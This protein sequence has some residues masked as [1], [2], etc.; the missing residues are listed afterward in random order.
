MQRV[1]IELMKNFR[2]WVQ[3]QDYEY[4]ICVDGFD[5]AR[6]LV[7]QLGHSFVFRSAQPISQNAKTA[8]CTFQ[9]PCGPQLSLSKLSKLLTGF[10]EVTLLKVATAV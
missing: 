2:V 3:P 10:P 6:W 4:L 1:E 7:D 8:L 9:I 5:N